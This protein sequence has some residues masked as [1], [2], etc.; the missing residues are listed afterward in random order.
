M[1]Q[2]EKGAE[3]EVLDINLKDPELNEA[4]V[5]IQSNYRGFQVRKSKT[6]TKAEAAV[7]DDAG[8]K[9][10]VVNSGLATAD[11]GSHQ[12]QGH[13]G[14]E[15]QQKMDKAAT[16]IQSHFRGYKDRKELQVLAYS[17]IGCIKT[18][19]KVLLTYVN[20]YAMLLNQSG[21]DAAEQKWFQK[22]S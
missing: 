20:K 12:D 5:K 10:S 1:T 6:G 13:G 18:Q 15:E 7:A 8:A 9:A 3:D 19:I 14:E 2:A 21:P 16:T 11:I 22:G 17:S 4:A